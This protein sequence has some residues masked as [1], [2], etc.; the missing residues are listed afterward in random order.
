MRRSSFWWHKNSDIVQMHTHTHTCT[1]AHTHTHTHTDRQTHR[2]T[3][4]HT[5]NVSIYVS[6]D[7]HQTDLLSFR[8]NACMVHTLFLS[9]LYT[10][11]VHMIYMCM[12]TR[13]GMHA[14]G[15]VWICFVFQRIHFFR[16]FAENSKFSF[17]F[18]PKK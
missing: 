11:N 7:T 15:C 4:T 17:S 6:L 13:Q 3:Q 5:C 14:F 10:H 16:A 9:F 18:F 1:H 2:H 12:Q 8:Y